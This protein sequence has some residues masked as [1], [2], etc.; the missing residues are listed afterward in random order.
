MTGRSQLCQSAVGQLTLKASVY[1]HA[2]TKDDVSIVMYLTHNIIQGIILHIPTYQ[3][4]NMHHMFP[5]LIKHV[6]K[7]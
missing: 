3:H 1:P 6:T 7:L 4:S 5:M 2:I